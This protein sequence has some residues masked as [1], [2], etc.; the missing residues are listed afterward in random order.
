MCLM[1]FEDVI[2]FSRY[3]KENLKL[4]ETVLTLLVDAGFKLNLK[5]CF[6]V[7]KEV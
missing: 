6:F 4:L 3:N 5:K 7:K 2:I 1:Y